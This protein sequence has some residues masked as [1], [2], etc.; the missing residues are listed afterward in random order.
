MQTEKITKEKGC[1]MIGTQ[2][3]VRYKTNSMRPIW[4]GWN[5]SDVRVRESKS[6]A[7]PLGYTPIITPALF[8][9]TVL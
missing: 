7:L 5:D 8:G 9:V 2:D 4:L 6:L 1:I 3:A